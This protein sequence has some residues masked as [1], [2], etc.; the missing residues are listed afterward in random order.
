MEPL[1]SRRSV[2][3]SSLAFGLAAGDL[4]AQKLPAVAVAP[5]EV[6]LTPPEKTPSCRVPELIIK[7]E[8]PLMAKGVLFQENNKKEKYVIVA[9]DWLG[10][11]NS[12]YAKMQTEVAQ[13]IGTKPENVAI[14]F[15]HQHTAPMF[16][17]DAQNLLDQVKANVRMSNDE[18]L[19]KAAGILAKTVAAAAEKLVPLTHYA[20]S[21]AVADRLASSRRILLPDGRLF[22]RMSS[23]K[24]NPE[25]RKM[26]EGKIDPFV[27]TVSLWSHE[28]PVAY[29]HYYASH[30]M[31]YYGDG[32]ASYDVPG[33]ARTQ[34]E[35]DTKVPQI[36]FTGCGA[37]VAF[38]KYNDGLPERRAELADRL[39]DALKRS[40]DSKPALTPVS[41]LSWATIE[42][43]FSRREDAEFSEETHR[44]RIAD[45]KLNGTLRAKSAMLLAYHERLKQ[46]QQPF[47]ASVLAL[48]R[49]RL[50]QLPSEIFVEYQLYLQSQFPSEFVAVAAYGDCAVWYVPDDPAYTAKGGYEQTWAFSQPCEAKLKAALKK[51]GEKVAVKS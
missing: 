31:S 16:D 23:T 25:A 45:E 2:L 6:E 15:V 49:T 46:G 14:Q 36:Y 51:L 1:L 50:F 43:P 42:L 47:L 5:F 12:S 7:F 35:K 40:I 37:D 20:T 11:C 28:K 13:A 9:I 19:D 44:K 30:P 41:E 24:N 22:S 39:Y 27:R 4:F 38:G 18:Y 33:L 34:L 32:R 21:W 48:G 17:R 3:G 8:H 10:V 26:P 29:L